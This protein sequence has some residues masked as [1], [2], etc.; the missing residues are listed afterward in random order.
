M[1]SKQELAL[2]KR[3][4]TIFDVIA[5]T[6]FIVWVIWILA[7]V[8]GPLYITLPEIALFTLLVICLCAMS[9]LVHEY[10][11]S[12]PQRREI[13]QLKSRF[14]QAKLLE[15][16]GSLQCDNCQIINN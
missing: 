8:L 10:S 14:E 1:P 5:Y 3:L 16:E 13:A 2:S 6:A 4:N 9:I 12:E 7:G 15:P 11:I